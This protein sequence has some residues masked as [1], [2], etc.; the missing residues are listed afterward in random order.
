[1]SGT[2]KEAMD[3]MSMLQSSRGGL[4]R[5]PSVRIQV[6]LLSNSFTK[7]GLKTQSKAG[8]VGFEFNLTV[9]CIAS[10]SRLSDSDGLLA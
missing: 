6:G 10:L 9:Y 8:L 2:E 4:I 5:I 3:S 7:F 1:M